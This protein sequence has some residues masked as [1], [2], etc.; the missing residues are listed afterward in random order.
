MAGALLAASVVIKKGV[1]LSGTLG[2]PNAA[3]KTAV[4]P[5]SATASWTFLANG[6]LVD[7]DGVA[8]N[9]DPVE[10]FYPES[11]DPFATY[12]V[13]AT[14]ES[15]TSPG[16]SALNTWHALSG[17]EQWFLNQ[18][19]IGSNTCVL[20]LEIATDS[21]GTNIVATGYYSLTATVESGG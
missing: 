12:Y 21:G 19:G 8:Y 2:T 9:P 10:W 13:R 20:K 4:S 5:A 16:G 6:T 3:A 7:G 18:V 11:L 15:G 14:L 17:P 1:A